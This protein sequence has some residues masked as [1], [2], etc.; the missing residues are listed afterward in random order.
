MTWLTNIA[1][2]TTDPGY[3]VFN[4]NH[5]SDWNQFDIWTWTWSHGLKPWTGPTS[6]GRDQ[7]MST[8]SALCFRFEIFL[9]IRYK[10]ALSD[11]LQKFGHR[12]GVISV[13]LVPKLATRNA[14]LAL[15]VSIS[16]YLHQPESH[17]FSITNIS[18]WLRD[19]W[20]HRSDLGQFHGWCYLRAL[21][22]CFLDSNC[23]VLPNR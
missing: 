19:T 1:R 12:V 20:T 23:I 7:H 3:K 8:R 11:L 17:Q 13:E 16:L 2:C 22:A 6:S 18:L 9:R 14:L 10:Y 5:F 21:R 15:S 4:L